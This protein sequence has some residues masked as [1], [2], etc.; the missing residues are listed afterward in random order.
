MKFLLKFLD[1]NIPVIKPNMRLKLI[2]D[3]FIILIIM[4]Y[5]FI[6]PMQLSFDF[7]Y[8]EEFEIFCEQFHIKKSI[9]HFIIFIPELILITDTMLK[10]ISGYY[11]NGV[12]VTEKKHIIEHYLKKGL[13]LDLMAYTPVLAHSFLILYVNGTLIKLF[14][15]LMFCKMKRV[16][17]A[18]S[19]YQEIISS[20]GRDDYV[21]GAAR[22]LGTILFVTHLHACAWHAMAYFSDSPK[23]WLN[24]WLNNDLLVNSNWKD[25]YLSSLFW[26][27]SIF[28]TMGFGKIS[29][30]NNNE[31][32]L[33]I[34]IILDSVILFGYSLYNVFDIFKAMH[35]EK[36]E[37]K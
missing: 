35:Q 37:Y 7:F 28:S 1:K 4:M 30:Q 36:K 34:L 23:N 14:Q 11:E 33:G 12:M 26:A 15:L 9:S 3:F 2:W 29:P 21:V 6:V 22:L 17:V 31:L 5:F 24:D 8:D 13:F 27:I 16:A 25:R 18:L 32:G 19:T 10:F 20:S